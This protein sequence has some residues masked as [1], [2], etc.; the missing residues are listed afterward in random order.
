MAT[1]KWKPLPAFDRVPALLASSDFATTSYTIHLTD[2]ANVWVETLDRKG[3]GKRALNEDTSIDP[4][5]GPDQMILLLAKLQAAFDPDSQDSSET[6]LTLAAS[7]EDDEG[8]LLLN[9]TCNLPGG[10]KPLQWPFQFKKCPWPTVASQLVLPLIQAQ[11]CRAREIENLIRSLQEKDAIIEKLVDK[12][13]NAGIGLENIFNTLSGK[14]KLS[15]Q[16]AEEKIKGL[17]PFNESEWRTNALP[18]E[19]MPTDPI[20]LISN[21]FSKPIYC[22]EA[23]I[24]ASDDL[25]DWWTRFGTQPIAAVR[26]EPK[27]DATVP[28]LPQESS[29]TVDEGDDFQVQVTPPHLASKRRG[30]TSVGGDTTTDDEAEAE[31]IS[32]SHPVTS[33]QEAPRLGA[34]KG[35]KAAGHSAASRSSLPKAAAQDETASETDTE[36]MQS[37][38]RKRPA[39][40]LGKIGQTTKP[41]EPPARSPSPAPQ[42]P[43]DDETASG[44]DD[45]TPVKPASPVP[46][47]EPLPKRK[48]VSLACPAK[49]KVASP[50][51][52]DG[53]S[54]DTEMPDEAA[55]AASIPTRKK[56]GAIGKRK[57]EK[58]SDGE[59]SKDTPEEPQ[60]EEQK[61]ERKRAELAKELERKAT[62]APVKKK[63]KF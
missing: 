51:P 43:K 49:E 24:S 18:R 31:T 7:S 3:I 46:S 42:D 39:A 34:I 27:S 56:L 60:T 61:A 50:S 35:K 48:L 4:T 36:P 12:L 63:R 13:G 20:S 6:S 40:R 2:L 5:E 38:P 57:V 29:L 62:A 59:S 53:E 54:G 47:K 52:A 37:S 1:L 19:D 45:D 11:Q 44:S 30:D 25:A 14:R 21:V 33:R 58:R 32:D 41:A 17:A 28:S 26:S 9:I 16:V 22:D 15:R 55:P 8:S 23:R 10:L